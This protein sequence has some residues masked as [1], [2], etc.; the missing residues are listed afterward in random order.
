MLDQ[1]LTAANFVTSGQIYR[2][3]LDKERAGD[4]LG[5]DVQMIPHVTGEVKYRLRDLAVKTNAAL[6]EAEPKSNKSGLP[7]DNA[8][9]K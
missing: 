8:K 9:P 5:R 1:D 2:S 3:V 6:P 7:E 4:Y